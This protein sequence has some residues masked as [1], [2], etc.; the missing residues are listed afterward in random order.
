MSRVDVLIVAYQRSPEWETFIQERYQ[1]SAE[2]NVVVSVLHNI[3]QQGLAI[4]K[5][6]LAERTGSPYVMFANDDALPCPGWDRLLIDFLDRHRDCGA[7]IP[8]PVGDNRHA[9]VWRPYVG[10]VQ[11]SSC[12][13]SREL[14]ELT[15]KSVGA[16]EYLHY[17]S[18]GLFS[19]FFAVMMRRSAWEALQGW[20]ERFRFFGGDREML[21]RLSLLGLWVAR[22]PRC[23][24]WHRGGDSIGRNTSFS[25]DREW[26]HRKLVLAAIARGQV[27][28]WHE[29]DSEERAAVRAN[30]MLSRIGAPAPSLSIIIPTLGRPSLQATLDSLRPQLSPVDEVIVVADGPSSDAARMAQAAGARY[31]ETAPTRAWGHAQRN[32]GMRMAQGDFLAFLDDDDVAA[33]DALQTMRGAMLEDPTR[34]CVFRMTHHGRVLWKT[35]AISFGNVSTQMYLFPNDPNRL[36]SWSVH[37]GYRDGA[38]GDFCWLRDTAKL[39][40]KGAI[41]WRTEIVA[42]LERHRRGKTEKPV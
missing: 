6:R 29:L 14:A 26:R 3:E 32:A 31:E 34:P 40:P 30:P 12:P 28:R 2:G 18:K 13:T 11:L 4:A 22:L 36:A 38:G 1:D 42:V 7:V 8:L 41:R 15:Q 16:P 19:P 5:N 37:P 35:P 10:N 39:Y 25:Y 20:D 9:D 27:P 23:P 21:D 24:F 33:S 17:K